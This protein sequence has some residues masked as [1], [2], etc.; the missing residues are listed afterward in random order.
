[1]VYCFMDPTSTEN[2]DYKEGC[3]ILKGQLAHAHIYTEDSGANMQ[4][5]IW[6]TSA[7]CLVG[8]SWELNH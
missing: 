8:K 4:V 1:M 3:G 7:Q 6:S 2:I 5:L